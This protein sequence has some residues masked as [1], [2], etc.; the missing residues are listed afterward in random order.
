[1]HLRKFC[2]AF[3]DGL[4]S[5][6]QRCAQ[7]HLLHRRCTPCRLCETLSRQRNDLD[8]NA[9]HFCESACVGAA[10]HTLEMFRKFFCSYFK[11][12]EHPYSDFNPFPMFHFSFERTGSFASEKLVERLLRMSEI[13]DPDMRLTS[14]V[15]NVFFLPRLRQTLVYRSSSLSVFYCTS[16]EHRVQMVRD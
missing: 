2:S 3:A 8:L 7:G 12:T 14:G 13:F 5:T 4:T 16:L 1:M 15:I 9:R 6:M 10:E 11:N